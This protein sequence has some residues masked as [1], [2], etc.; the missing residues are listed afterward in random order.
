[1]SAIRNR[2]DVALHRS[3]ISV[4]MLANSCD[5][6]IQLRLSVGSSRTRIKSAYWT[7]TIADPPMPIARDAP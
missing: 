6:T 3:L 7:D 1:V 4:G 5:S 2:K